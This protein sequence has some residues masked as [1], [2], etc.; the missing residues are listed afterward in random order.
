MV[1]WSTKSGFG[2]AIG[3]ALLLAGCGARAPLAQPSLLPYKPLMQ[4]PTE[5]HGPLKIWFLGTSTIVLRDEDTAI[6]TDGF[7]TRPSSLPMVTSALS[8]DRERVSE[9]LRLGGFD[10]RPRAQALFV[11]HAHHDHVL[12][13]AA[14]AARTGAILIGDDS[15]ANVAAGHRPE[16]D[17]ICVAE[18]GDRFEVGNF[19]VTVF[20]TPHSAGDI[21]PIRGKVHSS[22]VQERW[23]GDFRTTTSHAY[24]VKHKDKD[25]RVRRI[26]IVPSANYNWSSFGGAKAEVVFLAVAKL[27]KLSVDEAQEYWRRAVTETGARLV[28]PIHW[29]DIRDRLANDRGIPRDFETI[30]YLQD[31]FRQAMAIIL[32]LALRQKVE[33]RIPARAGPV[34]VSP[35][36]AGEKTNPPWWAPGGDPGATDDPA[37][38][39]VLW[40]LPNCRKK[41]QASSAGPGQSQGFAS[42]L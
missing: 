24:H 37:A 19:T 20:E 29:D 32:P 39:A 2:G 13:S 5:T 11:A 36:G 6:L 23:L 10:R 8:S 12:D 17:S 38:K 15:S 25:G 28:V 40:K 7:F 16:L 4:A 9:G 35:I 41:A 14:V 30:P 21:P 3:A 34:Q 33:V 1:G 22:R 27:H 42:L 26:L 18:H 31:D